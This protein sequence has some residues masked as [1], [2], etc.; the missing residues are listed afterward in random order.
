MYVYFELRIDMKTKQKNNRMINL[1][2]MEFCIIILNVYN[3][4]LETVL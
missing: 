3:F 4:I 2:V 1:Y